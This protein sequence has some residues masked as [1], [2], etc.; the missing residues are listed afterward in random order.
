VC[1]PLLTNRWQGRSYAV[2][3]RLSGFSE[4]RLVSR[5]QKIWVAPAIMRWLEATFARSVVA[6][7]ASADLETRFVGPLMTL[8]RD[9]MIPAEIRATARAAERAL[10]D[11]RVRTVTC[12]EHCDFWT[13]NILFERSAVHDLAPFTRRFRVIDWGGCRLDGYPGI[14][15]VRLLLSAFGSR[16]R[17]RSLINQYCERASLSPT[18]LSV[19]CLC[20]LGK[21]AEDLNHFPKT[22]FVHLVETCT[23]FLTETVFSM[24]CEVVGMACKGWPVLAKGPALEGR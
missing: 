21:I 20:A 8:I 6:C 22:Q 9:N 3:P 15:A 23:T 5:A 13:G 19:S 24:S 16:S 4:N 10:A 12:L 14:D 2:Y 17:S 7:T 1:V 18:D 11:G